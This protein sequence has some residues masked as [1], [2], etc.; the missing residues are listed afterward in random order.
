MEN[1]NSY[2][3]KHIRLDTNEVFY[4]GI[5]S[6]IGYKRAH[7]KYNRNLHWKNVV[8]KTE[9]I[10]E[11]VKD[12]LSW[13]DAVNL[14]I[15]LIKKYGRSDLNEGTLVN[16]TDGGDGG[17]TLSNH[18]NRN[19]ILEKFKNRYTGSL[20]PMYGKRHSKEVIDKLKCER[21]GA[22]NPFYGKSH[23]DNHIKR[24][25][26][27]SNPS[28]RCEVREKLRGNLNACKPILQFTKEGVFLREWISATHVF[29]ELGIS[30]VTHCCRGSQK[31]AGNFVWKYK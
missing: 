25:S 13:E 3:Y 19:S 6:Q 15:E 16:M 12:N 31:T 28:K 27:D 24:M 14:E 18:I 20:N 17:D 8:N 2:V 29:R 10:V 9:Y 23:S 1:C 11:I 22:G 26:G 4:I 30:N 7:S 21:I 5:G